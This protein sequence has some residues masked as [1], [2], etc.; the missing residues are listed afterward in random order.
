M[1]VCGCVHHYSCQVGISMVQIISSANSVYDIPW[2]TSFSSF[3][4]LLKVFMVDLITITK[5][6][7]GVCW[8]GGGTVRCVRVG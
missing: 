6:L 7:P 8:G 1:P 5:V 3:L 2:P 4:D